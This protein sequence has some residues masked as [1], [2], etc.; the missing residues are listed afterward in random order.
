[1]TNIGWHIPLF[2]AGVF[3][4]ACSQVL[5][6]ISAGKPHKNVKAEYF[7][8]YV[9]LAYG[10]FGLSLLISLYVLRY[11]PISLVPIL[12]SA[13][14]IFVPLL[15]IFILGEKL[16]IMQVFGMVLICLGIVI[17]NL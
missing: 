3:I 15:S 11:V 13:I 6:K 16:K 2:L 1:M 9:I 4:A 12:E 5:L 17:F 10:M 14:F 7:N 8:F